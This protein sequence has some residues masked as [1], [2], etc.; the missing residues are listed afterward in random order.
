MAPV[1]RA[2]GANH[3]KAVLECNSRER[4]SYFT[5]VSQIDGGI[6]DDA[7]ERDGLQVA[8]TRVYRSLPS[9]EYCSRLKGRN[10]EEQV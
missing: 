10:Q 7:F 6:E 1:R 4:T 2:C 5:A 3:I 9:H 8:Q